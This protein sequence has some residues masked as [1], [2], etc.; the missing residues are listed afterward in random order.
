MTLNIQ[1]I[2][3]DPANTGGGDTIKDA[4]D[5][6]NEN[7]SS[8]YQTGLRADSLYPNVSDPTTIQLGNLSVTNQVLG[9]L[10]LSGNSTIFIYDELTDSYQPVVTTAESFPGGT[11]AGQTAF[12]DS[13]QSTSP[14]TGAIT[15]SGG[16]GIAKN[17]HVGELAVIE[18]NIVA[19]N[20]QNSSSIT[21]GSFITKGGIGV[22]KSAYIGD[23]LRVFG[24][25]QLG[26]TTLGNSGVV[27]NASTVSTSPGTGALI[28]SGGAGVVG[29]LNVGGP[30]TFAS[31]LTVSGNVNIAGNIAFTTDTFSVSDNLV[32][33]H[34]PT[35]GVLFSNDGKDI[36]VV[37]RHY[38]TEHGDNNA[39]AGF[40]NSTKAFEYYLTGSENVGTGT[41]TGSIRG[42]IRGGDIRSANTTPS[43][44][45]STGAIVSAGGLGVSGNAHIGGDI[46]A[47]ANVYVDQDLTV[48]G[49]AGVAGELVVAGGILGIIETS[50]QPNITSV[51]TLNGV[52]I[53][54]NA[55]IS[56]QLT[57]D[58]IQANSFGSISSELTGVIQTPAQPNITSVGTLTSLS[59]SGNILPSANVTSNLGTSTLWWDTTY[60]SD[61]I[62]ESIAADD[63]T[64]VTS[65]VG[66]IRSSSVL[67]ATVG[68]VGT[69]LVGTLSTSSQPN[70]T[71][72]G[73]L[74]TL[75]MAGNIIPSAN[76]TYNLG[77]TSM[78]WNLV[79]GRSVH[80][81]YADLAENYLADSDYEAGTVL[82]FGGNAEVTV[83]TEFADARVAGIV[84]TNPAY[85]MNAV[86]PGIPIALRGRVPCKVVGQVKK[87]D[88]LVTSEI[89]G[90][91]ISVGTD[92]TM[93][94]FVVA[95]SLEDKTTPEVS[96]IEV[97]VV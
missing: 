88:L 63:I 49:N 34:Q 39:F 1:Y 38:S 8:L 4:F 16:A 93:G 66:T 29:N 6:V 15:V 60:T 50:A 22:A 97:V 82:V 42:T 9:N 3:T 74:T 69:V 25:S 21:T 70:I 40:I 18:G 53:N 94:A 45:T 36:G 85:L 80:A 44:S 83:T 92:G 67:S 57:V 95:K 13:T 23:A 27:L 75:T 35:G 72:V 79:Y 62:V 68:N 47:E 26:T 81:Q 86:T 46:I 43:V 14:T 31:D 7:F 48:D 77:S 51:G 91:A 24:S 55:S 61:L 78:W 11:I 87:G 12:A 96:Y 73:N 65:N 59:V 32:E 41:F 58:S 10:Y 28:V 90:V 56:G 89:P 84:S 17:L 71:T 64:A 76:V 33:F 2:R 20:S 5:K 52:A 19:N 54:G 30:S 37:Y